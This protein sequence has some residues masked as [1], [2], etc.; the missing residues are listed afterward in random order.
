M[1][2]TQLSAQVRM[3]LIAQLVNATSRVPQKLLKYLILLFQYIFLL[4][5]S[6]VLTVIFCL[7]L[8]ETALPEKQQHCHHHLKLDHLCNTVIAF[9]NI[10]E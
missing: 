5:L 9:P 2:T 6:V 3:I 10:F 4:P 8:N 7:N 1:E